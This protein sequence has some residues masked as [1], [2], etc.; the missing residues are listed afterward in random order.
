MMNQGDMVGNRKGRVFKV[1]QNGEMLPCGTFLIGGIV[2]PA[3]MSLLSGRAFS[4]NL[5]A[6]TTKDEQ[7]VMFE[8]I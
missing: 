7:H 1:T 8:Y 6:A 5:G 3:T 4:G 2:T